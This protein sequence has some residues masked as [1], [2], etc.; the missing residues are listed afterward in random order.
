MNACEQEKCAHSFYLGKDDFGIRGHQMVQNVMTCIGSKQELMENS[1]DIRTTKIKLDIFAF[2]Y[3][4]PVN[5]IDV[6][7]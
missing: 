1:F 5:P 7:T 3:S 2:L 6:D 4:W